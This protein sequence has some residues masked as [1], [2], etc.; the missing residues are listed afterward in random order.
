[1]VRPRD[2]KR[3]APSPTDM[4]PPEDVAALRQHRRAASER[5]SKAKEDARRVHIT[6]SRHG[7]PT[8]K[9][10]R[11]IQVSTSEEAEEE[12]LHS[13]GMSGRQQSW[14]FV[15]VSPLFSFF[16]A[17]V[18]CGARVVML[19]AVR[20]R[21]A[22]VSVDIQPHCICFPGCQARHPDV[23]SDAKP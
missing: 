15:V 10:A 11:V 6:K 7:S 20:A 23:Q 16:C 3:K 9:R 14:R 2:R 12:S 18:S 22:L 8:V 19:A 1:M 13:R 4:A 5:R 17:C 21:E